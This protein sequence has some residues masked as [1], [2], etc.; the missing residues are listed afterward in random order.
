VVSVGLTFRLSPT[1]R[2]GGSVEDG[3]Q[4]EF[5]RR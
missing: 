1:A 2:S 3:N 5:M 4:A